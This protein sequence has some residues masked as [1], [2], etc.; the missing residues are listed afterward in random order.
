MLAQNLQLCQPMLLKRRL[1]LC[2]AMILAG[3]FFGL[4]G[5]G[6]AA[7]I[8]SYAAIIPAILGFLGLS[9]IFL[10]SLLLV[11]RGR[12]SITIDQSGISLP[13]GSILCSDLRNIL[14]PKEAMAAIYKH[15]CLRGRL[16]MIS[17]L[18]GDKIPIQVRNYCEL[19][20]FL[21]HCRQFDLPVI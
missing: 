3:A 13:V 11:R 10:G 17:L 4:V 9:N 15:E 19:K 6:S 18:N 20:K 1:D 2:I 12:L 21:T 14:V 16:V 8:G 5:F 7:A